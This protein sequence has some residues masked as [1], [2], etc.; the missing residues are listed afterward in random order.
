MWESEGVRD[1]W[2]SRH[3]PLEPV[4][5]G[6]QQRRSSRGQW[7][8]L[9][10][11]DGTVRHEAGGRIPRATDGLQRECKIRNSTAFKCGKVNI[12]V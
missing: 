1:G 2:K 12:M 7:S 11:H 5:V 9:A 8:A 10:G 3:W 6:L 4:G